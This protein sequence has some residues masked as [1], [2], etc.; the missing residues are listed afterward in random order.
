M[1]ESG[2]V[3]VTHVAAAEKLDL[4]LLRELQRIIYLGA[5]VSHRAFK[6]RVPKQE[7]DSPQVLCAL[8]DQGRLRTSHRVRSVGGW[9]KSRRHDPVLDDPCVLPRGDVRGV[10]HSTRK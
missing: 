4:R 3:G 7:L 10:P 9:I 1:P 5:K 2:H 8:E 6:L